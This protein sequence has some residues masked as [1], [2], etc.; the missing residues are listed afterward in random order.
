MNYR[1]KEL[2]LKVPS[3]LKNKITV[4]GVGRIRVKR[5]GVVYDTAG[6]ERISSLGRGK[7]PLSLK[8]Q[9]FV[10]YKNLI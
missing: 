8:R 2:I 6:G 9:S 7:N 1:K 5:Q 4:S 10:R 3:I